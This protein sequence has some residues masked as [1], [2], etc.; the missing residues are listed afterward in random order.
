[1]QAQRPGLQ[2]F[3][4][5]ILF[6]SGDESGTFIRGITSWPT[7]RPHDSGES[8][9][10]MQTATEPVYPAG[11]PPLI[12]DDI[13]GGRLDLGPESESFDSNNLNTGNSPEI[14]LA[15]DFT[16]DSGFESPNTIKS[17]HTDRVS[18]L[19]TK[20]Q[21]SPSAP[22][23]MLL[24]D[25][26]QNFSDSLGWT[27]NPSAVDVN[28]GFS[29]ERLEND[30]DFEGAARSPSQHRPFYSTV[31]RIAPQHNFL[32]MAIYK[33][34]LTLHPIPLKSRVE[35]QIPIKMILFPV[36]MGI[37]KLHLPT[38][39]ISKPKL[40]AQPPSERSP[41]TLELYTT[42]VCTSAIQNP[43]NRRRA[44]ERAAT[45]DI[46]QDDT[47]SNS[48]YEDNEAKLLNG[49][50]IKICIRCITRERKRATRNKFKRV[51]EEELWYKDEA[52][53]IVIFN[54]HE[55]KEWQPRTSQP[56][57][58]AE[59]SRGQ[60]EAFIPTGAL[61]VDAPMRITCY[62]RHQ[63]EKLGFQVI[64]TIKDYQDRLIAQE[65][66]SSIMITDDHDK[67][68]N[69]PTLSTQMSNASDGHP[70]QA[71]SATTT[72]C[73]LSRQTSRSALFGPSISKRR[74]ASGPGKLSSGPGQAASSGPISTVTSSAPS[75][76]TPNRSQ[77]MENLAIQQIFST[78]TS[79]YPSR[80][81]SSNSLRN[82]AQVYQQ[83]AQM[84]QAVP[85]GLY[86]MSIML[87]SYRPPTIHKLVSNEGP[88]AGGIE[89]TCLGSG[90]YQGLEVI[91]GDSKAI[92]TTF[93]G[94][95]SL[96]CLL[97]PSAFVGTVPVTFKHQYQH[98]QQQVQPYPTPLIP[99]Q[100]AIFKYIDDDEQQIIR[101]ALS[102]LGH[103]M[104]GKMED[105][106][107]LARRIVDDRRS[108]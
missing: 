17:P 76:F 9:E 24:A 75:P 54:T 100:Q 74:K 44:F 62:C 14:F 46:S 83:Q 72:V 29:D 4:R 91:F 12:L 7:R 102:V 58:E 97:P 94:E 23:T 20:L 5:V 79:E 95:T 10:V 78:P 40:L 50:D 18:L 32:N 30:F 60:L 65:I 93:W 59:A 13:S 57:S 48:S 2:H 36:P 64:F 92:T 43:E 90:F 33:P 3:N 67:T 11:S 98:Q 35:T 21:Q 6:R 27:I 19:D 103:R 16:I 52:K 63:K 49:G 88:K 73:S 22:S 106:R 108:S 70:S 85:N 104:T 82:S 47:R 77:S 15:E 84:T 38:H 99:Q 96:V 86:G 80:A 42:L 89:V 25:L 8:E 55:I 31:P 61:Q 28:F 107:E 56:P 53:R 68:H 51:E 66:T 69:L 1:M 71:T 41:D 105:V 45:Q 81:L 87:N 34:V 101:T 39:T 26:H 37:T